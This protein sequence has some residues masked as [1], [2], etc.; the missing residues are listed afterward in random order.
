MWPNENKMSYRYRE[1]AWI[2]VTMFSHLEY[3]YT[4]GSGAKSSLL[5]R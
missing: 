3:G 4:P 5:R 2:E 1:R